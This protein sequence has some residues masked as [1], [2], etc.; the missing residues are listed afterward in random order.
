MKMFVSLLTCMQLTLHQSEQD[1]TLLDG[2][3][4]EFMAMLM[5][6]IARINKK[7][8]GDRELILTLRG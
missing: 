7:G 1:T 6:V 2:K 8:R 3:R 5:F 4:L